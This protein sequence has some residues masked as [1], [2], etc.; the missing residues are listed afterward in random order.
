LFQEPLAATRAQQ[1]LENLHRDD[2]RVLAYCIMP[3]HVHVVVLLSDQSPGRFVQA[4]KS[5]TSRKMKR[6]G[7]DDLVWQRGYYDHVVRRAD[8]LL[9][10]IRYV[11]SNPVRK[12][13][14]RG[15][16]E[17]P[18]TGSVEWPDVDDSLLDDRTIENSVWSQINF[19]EES[20]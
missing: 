6:H 14:V 16:R 11:I 13:L 5:V 2:R 20:S 7:N 3:D 15:W 1:V 17:W 10:T 19:E 8:G 18:F 4:L 9:K 12:G